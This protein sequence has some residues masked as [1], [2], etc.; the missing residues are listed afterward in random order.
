MSLSRAILG[1]VL[2]ARRDEQ[3][4]LACSDSEA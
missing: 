3:F 4:L 2:S 1:Y